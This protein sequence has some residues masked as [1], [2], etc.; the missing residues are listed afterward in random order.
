MGGTGG[1]SQTGGV[2]HS[3][4]TASLVCSH[5]PIPLP[6]PLPHLS[7]SCCPLPCMQVIRIQPNEGIYLKINNKV[8]GLGLRIDTTRLDLTYRAKYKAHLPG[9][10][11]SPQTRCW[12]LFWHALCK[13]VLQLAT[14]EHPMSPPACLPALPTPPPPPPAAPH[15]SASCAADAYERLI[16]DCINGDRRLFIRNDELEVAWDKFTPVLKVGGWVGWGGWLAGWRG[17]EAPGELIWGWI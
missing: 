11:T 17:V 16:L 13:G 1:G 12:H 15:P 2:L 3:H 7:P 5:Q 4:G 9:Q 10:H 8:P 6:L 14:S